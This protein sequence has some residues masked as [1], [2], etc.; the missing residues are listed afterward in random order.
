MI[1]ISQEVAVE[2]RRWRTGISIASFLLA[3]VSF[4]VALG[5]FAYGAVAAAIAAVATAS[6]TT[7]SLPGLIMGLTYQVALMHGIV[8]PF[9]PSTNLLLLLLL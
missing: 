7:K 4:G 8:V 6:V 2:W 3:V 1:G 9:P 5:I